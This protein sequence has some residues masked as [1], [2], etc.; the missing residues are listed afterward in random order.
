MKHLALFLLIFTLT[1]H[2]Q[3]ELKFDK[4]YVESE[5]QWVAFAADSIGNHIYG[6][7]YIDSEAGLTLDYSG[8]FSI[9]NG[10]YI[11]KKK[12]TE[13]SMKYRL[14]PNN[15]TVA[16]IPDARLK[17]LAVDKIPDWLQYYKKNEGSIGRLYRWGYLY[18]GYHECEKALTY[19]EKAEKIDPD[20][21]GL[22]TE[23]AFSY[24]ALGRFE[25]AETALKKALK[26]NP[27]DCYTLKELAYTYKNLL[28]AEKSAEVYNKMAVACN[29]KNYIQETAYNLAFHYYEQKDKKNF[30]KW[31]KEARK[32]GDNNQYTQ[33]LAL[34]EQ[35]LE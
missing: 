22:Q 28:Q 30:K 11:S 5:D 33:Q 14:E 4:R 16:F 24:N 17:E 23:L 21:S 13:G 1:I 3:N 29:E 8:T 32:W 18:N 19:L 25:E 20:F 35:K 7:I 26:T 9:E 6:F 12:V 31:A 10:K 15:N 2:A 34:L 27:L